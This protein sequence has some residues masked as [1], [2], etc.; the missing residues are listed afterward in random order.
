M[1]N[2][3]ATELVRQLTAGDVTSAEVTRTYLDRIERYDASVRAFLRVEPTSALA[4]GPK[5][6]HHWGPKRGSEKGTSLILTA[7]VMDDSMP[8]CHE[9]HEQPKAE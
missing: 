9:P 6:G 4:Q 5:R 3:T 2:L 7:Q 8:R 1:T